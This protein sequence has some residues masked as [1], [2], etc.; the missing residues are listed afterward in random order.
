MSSL[1]VEVVFIDEILSHPNA[2]RLE[3]ARISGW[4]CVV[5]KGEYTAGQKV[6]YIPI[7][8]VLPH[9]LETK[10]F[11]IESKIKLEKSRVRTI[12][13]R[14]AISQG[15]ITTLDEVGLSPHLFVGDDVANLL[16]I[17]K[18]EP[19]VRSIPGLMRGS[20]LSPKKG[21]SGFRKYTDIEN[22][23]HYNNLFTLED[24]IWVSEKLHGTSARYALLPTEANTFWKKVRRFL[25]IL[26]QFEFCLGSR[27]VQLQDKLLYAGYYESNVYAKIAEQEHIREKL[28]PG[29]AIYGE[30]I[31]SGIQ[32][33]YA[34]GCT[35]GEHK[36]YV[37]DVM[38]DGRWLGFKELV[39]FC[40]E[41]ELNLVP[42]L[43]MG[44]FN[45]D[46]I[47]E[48][49]QGDS[50]VGR[51]KVREGVVIKTVA[52]KPCIIGRSVVKFINDEYLL[53]E[54]SDFH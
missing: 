45:M 39:E 16:H 33:G 41:R 26:P 2:D 50:L 54:Q 51:Q 10:L 15:I 53:R 30:I 46:L 11:P 49:R 23:K 8:A 21:N 40:H 29:E 48:L 5:R 18:Y 13:L 36:F 27:N 19:P 47:Y 3:I 6:V 37:Y 44:N 12:K 35:P 22:F 14:G 1:K 9:E 25:R 31:G 32:K 24:V 52:E 4:T 28:V 43:Y 34:Y 17:T 42:F 38:R 20:R 7:D